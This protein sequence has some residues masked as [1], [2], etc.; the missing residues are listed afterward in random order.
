MLGM[1]GVGD[2]G[3]R[4]AEGCM[5]RRS[6]GKVAGLAIRV[7]PEGSTLWGLEASVGGA[8]TTQDRVYLLHAG[9]AITFLGGF[10][11]PA[12]SCR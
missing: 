9:L 11:L 10:D 12:W 1:G 8:L 7:T 5:G 6:G 2:S 4:D 3:Y